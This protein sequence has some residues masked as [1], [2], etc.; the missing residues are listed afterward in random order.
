MRFN[1]FLAGIV[2]FNLYGCTNKYEEEKAIK[3]NSAKHCITR[4]SYS[5]YSNDEYE[6]KCEEHSVKVIGFIT[7]VDS[8]GSTLE[9]TLNTSDPTKGDLD[10]NDKFFAETKDLTSL[11]AIGDKVEVTGV[12]TDRSLMGV[13]SIE[14]AAFKVVKLT[15]TE[16][17][18][19][20]RFERKQR[21][22]NQFSSWNGSH[23]SLESYVKGSMK[24]PSSYAH[25]R[26]VYTDEGDYI[27]VTTQ[28]SGTNSFGGTVTNSA[29]ARIDLEGNIVKIIH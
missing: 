5:E 20:N 8:S 1:I 25:V 21:I 23:P 19:K 7:G 4:S 15:E 6:A 22:E 18:A 3:E 2:I 13:A 27:L 14:T 12:F 9:F 17:L 28:F 16:Q 26:T 10:E 24:N 11:P 29:S